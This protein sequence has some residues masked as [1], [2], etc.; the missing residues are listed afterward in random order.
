MRGLRLQT[1]VT[2]LRLGKRRVV[3][4]AN[5]LPVDGF[6]DG[7]FRA[8]AR[9]ALAAGGRRD[10]LGPVAFSSAR[11]GVAKPSTTAIV[12]IGTI[13]VMAPLLYRLAF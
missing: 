2:T 5:R 10:P 1:S 9:F 13:F 8:F 4:K 12:K 11:S 3:L 7:A 6:F